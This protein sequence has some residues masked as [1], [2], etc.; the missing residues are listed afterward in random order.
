MSLVA[1]YRLKYS[2]FL[3]RFSYRRCDF[4]PLS[5]RYILCAYTHVL[6]IEIYNPCCSSGGEDPPQSA[7]LDGL[8]AVSPS[9]YTRGLQAMP[10]LRFIRIIT[11]NQTPHK[12]PASGHL[13]F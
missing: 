2:A 9:R 8:S 4:Q 12:P 3:T 11:R 5:R 10:A 1:L 7:C 13:S 6:S